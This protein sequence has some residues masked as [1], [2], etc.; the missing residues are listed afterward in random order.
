MV[1][2]S[3]AEDRSPV[4]Q[5]LIRE[6]APAKTEGVAGCAGSSSALFI[7]SEDSSRIIMPARRRCLL[8]RE[9]FNFQN[10]SINAQLLPGIPLCNLHLRPLEIDGHVLI[11]ADVL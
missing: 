10:P 4:L 11:K 1:W 2:G 3:L 5:K 6:A 7:L 8:A 9:T